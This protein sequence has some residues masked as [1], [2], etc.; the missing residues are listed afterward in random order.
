MYLNFKFS[1]ELHD[2][3]IKNY[4]T[5]EANMGSLAAFDLYFRE[6]IMMTRSLLY[7]SYIVTPEDM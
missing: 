5:V 2:Q 1:L 3:L 4:L 7:L 6:T